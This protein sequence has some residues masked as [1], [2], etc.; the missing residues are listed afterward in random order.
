MHA[1]MRGV[2]GCVDVCLWVCIY[3][4]HACTCP[5]SQYAHICTYAHR[6]FTHVRA[7]TCTQV[8][9]EGEM[10]GVDK[11]V[12]VVSTQ[13]NDGAPLYGVCLYWDEPCYLIYA[14]EDVATED[15]RQ[16][17]GAAE[18]TQMLL[19]AVTVWSDACARIY[20]CLL[21]YVCRCL[22][23]YMDTFCLPLSLSPSHSLTPSDTQTLTHTHTR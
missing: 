10:A 22:L 17:G 7:C 14:D 21:A 20:R 12:F 5:T 15:G 16:R 6:A 8:Y 4:Y 18:I 23:A 9:S 13:E 2:P 1:C 3:I 11:M 19:P